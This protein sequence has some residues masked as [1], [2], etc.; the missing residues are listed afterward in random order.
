MS[1]NTFQRRR[2][3]LTGGTALAAVTSLY[4]AAVGRG[5]LK[6]CKFEDVEGGFAS[7]FRSLVRIGNCY[8]NEHEA[9]DE[10]YVPYQALFH[11]VETDSATFVDAVRQHLLAIQPQV[12]REF[13]RREIV[14]CDGWV[15]A[16][17]EAQLCAA[18]AAYTNRI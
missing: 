16:R 8:L 2:Q 5:A 17:C 14:M 13:A 7:D 10:F 6:A 4:L 9:V 1:N 12:R 11:E 15:L 18:I 3:L